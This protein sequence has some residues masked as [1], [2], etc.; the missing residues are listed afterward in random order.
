MSD[1]AI[2]AAI[3]F[4]ADLEKLPEMMRWVGDRL[5]DV[6]FEN[7]EEKK[8]EVAVEEVLVNIISYAYPQEKGELMI[9]AALL[10]EKEIELT[11]QDQGI[12]FN[13]LQ[14]KHAFDPSA[15]LEER[16]EGG[17]GI[18]LIQEFADEMH[19]E[20]RD[21]FNVLSLKKFL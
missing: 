4:L 5:K 7:S 10:P 21:H 19:Y 2:K 3:S 20:R 13:P 1:D 9:T 11:F 14:K 16:E 15:P 8:L 17:L 12:P 6:G 18:P